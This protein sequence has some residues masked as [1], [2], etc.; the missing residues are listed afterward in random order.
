MVHQRDNQRLYGRPHHGA[1]PHP[2]DI[3]LRFQP[4]FLT[5]C[6]EQGG[7]YLGSGYGYSVK[8][9]SDEIADKIDAIANPTQNDVF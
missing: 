3:Q 4:V 8:L 5:I 7:I 6:V 9:S 1:A 2:L